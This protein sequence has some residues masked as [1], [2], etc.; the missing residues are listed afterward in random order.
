[1]NLWKVDFE[2]ATQKLLS[3]SLGQKNAYV[4]CGARLRSPFSN[5]IFVV[6]G[7]A[8]KMLIVHVLK[9]NQLILESTQEFSKQFTNWIGTLCVLNEK[10][11]VVC[12][13]DGCISIF[14]LGSDEKFFC[15]ETISPEKKNV[16]YSCLSL[17]PSSFLVAP[18][19]NCVELYKK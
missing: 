4:M 9:E 8:G 5:S 3:T 16:I 2:N 12:C 14:E 17:D 11:L 6:T 10:S 7:G 15:K 18:A 19:N 13:D 1:M